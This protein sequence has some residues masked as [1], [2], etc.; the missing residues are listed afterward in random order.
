MAVFSV[1]KDTIHK[2][3]AHFGSLDMGKKIVVVAT[4]SVLFVA[5]IYIGKTLAVKKSSP[6]NQTATT[7]PS[8]SAP[9]PEAAQ[10]V[11]RQS[12]LSIKANA[13]LAV[14]KQETI[15]VELTGTPVS[16]TDIVLYYDPDV[17]EVSEVS[18]GSVFDRILV[19]N[20]ENGR[21][22]FSAA[23]SPDRINSLKTGTVFTFELTPLA[24]ASSTTISFDTQETVT[25]LNG[26]NTLSD[27]QNMTFIVT[28]E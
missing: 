26:E 25:A 13:D 14:G 10:Q 24:P 7:Q 16:A 28:S 5:S 21:L 23:V 27:V 4:L 6:T 17:V 11:R 9:T 1:V 8:D 20:V 12:R 2:D 15:S 3:V 22:S 18:N 19:N